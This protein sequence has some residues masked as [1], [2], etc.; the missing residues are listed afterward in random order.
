MP[1]H[2]KHYD[3][4]AMESTQKARNGEECKKLSMRAKWLQYATHTSII[5]PFN[6]LHPSL[7]NKACR[8]S[9]QQTKGLNA[10]LFASCFW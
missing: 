10:V 6:V 7:L 5:I 9:L 2:T 4:G 1:T 8:P 3:V